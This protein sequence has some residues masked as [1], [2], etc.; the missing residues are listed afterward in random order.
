MVPKSAL[1][2]TCLLAA[3]VAVALPVLSRVASAQELPLRCVAFSP[4]AAGY[5]AEFGPHPPPHVIDALL[6]QARGSTGLNCIQTYGVLNGLDYAFH[7]AAARGMK[8]IA[9]IWLNDLA[10]VNDASIAKG[11]EVAR[12]HTGTIVRVSCGSEVRT[13][14]GPAVAEPIVQNC[15]TRLRAAGVTQPLT[16]IDTWWEWCNR[17]WPCQ[18]R[19]ISTQVD[20]IGINVFPWWENRYSGLF[21][22]TTAAEADE[23]HIARLQDVSAR[24]PSRHIVL[25]EFGW[26]AGPNGYSEANERTGQRCGVASEDN[27]RDVFEATIE[28]LTALNFWGT[29]FAAVRE[30][31]KARPEGPVGPY[32]GLIGGAPR[33]PGNLRIV[34]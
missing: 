8:V 15:L 5:D 23:F 18:V 32:W 30:P 21:P 29:A 28:R 3:A 25:T 1:R 14:L 24:Y 12:A 11:I 10:A 16:A 6:D 26:P 31:W 13:R 33:R 20:W 2:A 34:R 9:I 4:Y 17:A 27:Q 19:A 7:A 22:C